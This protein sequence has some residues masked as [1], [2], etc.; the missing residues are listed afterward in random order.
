MAEPATDNRFDPAIELDAAPLE[1]QSIEIEERVGHFGAAVIGDPVG[2]PLNAFHEAIEIIARI[3]NADDTDRRAL[4]EVATVDLGDSNV[5]AMAKAVLDA[6]KHLPLVLKRVGTLN[7]KFD[8]Q[9]RDRHT[10]SVGF[11]QR[12]FKYQIRI[13]SREPRLA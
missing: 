4:P 11:L 3:G 6:T 9:V 2:L 12:A 10:S 7:A 5:E 8:G 1:G 13:A